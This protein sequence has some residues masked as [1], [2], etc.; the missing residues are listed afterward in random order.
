LFT[1][2]LGIEIGVQCLMQGGT[3]VS[4]ADQDPAIIFLLEIG[5]QVIDC[6][7]I[8]GKDN[9]FSMVVTLAY[10]IY[11]FGHPLPFW[12]IVNNV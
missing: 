7:R 9:H 2:V 6:I 4:V 1:L 11:L 10:F 3:H 8:L 12:I 5:F